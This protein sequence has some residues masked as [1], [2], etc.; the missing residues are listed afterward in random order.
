MSFLIQWIS[1]KSLQNENTHT[2]SSRIQINLQLF[3][4]IMR[5]KLTSL[6]NNH[7]MLGFCSLIQVDS[8]FLH[9]QYIGQM[10]D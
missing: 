8:I 6:Y 9:T 1:E 4:H 2:L 10:R 7:L 5:T 3:V